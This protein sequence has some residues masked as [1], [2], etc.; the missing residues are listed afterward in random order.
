MQLTTEIMRERYPLEDVN[1]NLC[2]SSK[3][4]EVMNKQGY[5]I[6]RCDE[7]GL[8]FVSPRLPADALAESVY[9]PGY[10][11]AEKGYGLED[12]FGIANKNRSIKNGTERLRWIEKY[13]TRGRLLDV[14]CAAGFFMLAAKQRGWNVSGIEISDHAAAY[15]R[16]K[17]GLD[18][19]TGSFNQKPSEPESFDLVT[20]LDV[21]EHLPNPLSGLENARNILKPQG[22]LFVATPNFDS[23]PARVLGREWGLVAPEHHFYYFTPGIIEKM[24]AKAGFK[25]VARRF[26]LLGL[27][28]LLLSAGAI[29]KAGIPIDENKKV[30]IRQRLRLVRTAARGLLSA[31][32]TS[33]AAPLFANGKGVIIEVIARKI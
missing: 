26:P 5:S 21:I 18:V 3:K 13:A 14:G 25:I 17:F 9:G 22:L 20:M 24:L 15:A 31:I 23:L 1:C 10:F 30:A 33:I 28:D 27:N 12:H 16:E 2:G 4:T 7:C 32:D 6:V 29:R 19:K 8:V 11:D